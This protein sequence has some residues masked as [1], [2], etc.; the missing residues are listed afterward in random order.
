MQDCGCAHTQESASGGHTGLIN[1]CG[2]RWQ[3]DQK[4]G[5]G[6]CFSQNAFAL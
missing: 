4:T 2:C 6:K 3:C 5:R 1:G